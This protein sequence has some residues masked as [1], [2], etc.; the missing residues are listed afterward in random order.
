MDD[1]EEG[2]SFAGYF[3]QEIN[4]KKVTDEDVGQA[5]KRLNM[6][7]PETRRVVHL[8]CAFTRVR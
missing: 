6:G 4:L 5:V 1:T 7:Y 3:P 8:Q 2:R